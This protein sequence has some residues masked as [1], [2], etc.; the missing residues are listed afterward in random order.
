MENEGKEIEGGEGIGGGGSKRCVWR[1]KGV[2]LRGKTE[3]KR[4]EGGEVKWQIDR[5]GKETG[6]GVKKGL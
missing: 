5:N 4:E 6:G 1:K 3:R 2:S